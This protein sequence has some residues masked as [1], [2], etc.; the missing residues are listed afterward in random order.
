MVKKSEL[1]SYSVK[2][3]RELA[4]S[5]NIPVDSKAKKQLLIDT[6]YANRKKLPELQK[7][8]KPKRKVSEKQLAARK[9]FAE[10]AK[11]RKAKK[12]KDINNEESLRKQAQAEAILEIPVAENKVQE[13]INNTEPDN[14]IK[15]SLMNKSD[16]EPKVFKKE[17]QKGVN[18]VDGDKVV[19]SLEHNKKVFDDVNRSEVED[20]GSKDDE[21][22]GVE[23][24]GINNSRM[25]FGQ[26]SIDM[27]REL[28]KLDLINQERM[29]RMNNQTTLSYDD[30]LRS[31]IYKKKNDRFNN[32]VRL[33]NRSENNNLID[34]ELAE[35]EEEEIEKSN[36]ITKENTAMVIGEALQN[37]RQQLLDQ[38]KQHK[39]DSLNLLTDRDLRSVAISLFSSEASELRGKN[40]IVDFLSDR[41]SSEQVDRI[42]SDVA[43]KRVKRNSSVKQ[44]VKEPEIPEFLQ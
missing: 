2:E 5:N 33:I 14:T 13:L 17:Q 11:A 8:D 23:D 28:Y 1:K 7:K 12:Q 37:Y 18:V 24:F 9:R 41:L 40:E 42:L 29:N 36:Q 30:Y 44:E 20:I 22:L 39:V 38:T 4:K 34:L 31:A 3:L 19:G 16:I 26:E 21:N 35:L 10:M 32:I 27:N 43:L 25:T 6:I 15:G